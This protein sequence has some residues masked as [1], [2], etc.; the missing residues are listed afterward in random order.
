M[1]M[2]SLLCLLLLGLAGSVAAQCAPADPWITLEV[3]AGEIAAD[4]PVEVVD[5]DRRGCATL[6]WAAFD[7]R[8]GLWRRQLSKPERAALD[9]AIVE[10]K[11]LQFDATAVQKAVAARDGA[12]RKSAPAGV[13]QR[14]AVADG[15]TYRLSIDDPRGVARIEWYAP[16][17]VAKRHA[18]V[19]ALQDLVALIAQLQALAAADGKT[20][21][22][23][24]A[25]P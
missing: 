6:R 15:D 21:L 9:T 22:A 16:K 1:P 23:D 5:V 2:K 20:R 18:D 19:A 8:A 14:H 3:M 24:V 13:S 12:L 7:T 10:R 11:L 17:Q 25:S 4:E